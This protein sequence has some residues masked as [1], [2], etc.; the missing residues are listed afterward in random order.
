MSGSDFMK[1]TLAEL[2]HP[3]FGH[4]RS[5]GE[6]ARTLRHLLATAH[7]F[8]TPGRWG[9]SGPSEE[10]CDYGSCVN[11]A[12]QPWHS[13]RINSTSGHHGTTTWQE[14]HD[15]I[16]ECILAAICNEYPA[17]ERWRKRHKIHLH[18]PLRFPMAYQ[19]NDK[20]K[21]AWESVLSLHRHKLPVSTLNSCHRA[22]NVLAAPEL[23][24]SRFSITLRVCV[25]QRTEMRTSPDCYSRWDACFLTRTLK[26]KWNCQR[27]TFANFLLRAVE[28]YRGLKPHDGKS[29]NKA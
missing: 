28:F 14:N 26:P 1:K 20:E 10:L 23:E 22:V 18:M 7:T 5:I 4:Y 15:S 6:L 27:E 19:N 21:T 29:Q 13:G 11:C 8:R 17:C 25:T 9:S 16:Y 2:L 3:G 24:I 12:D